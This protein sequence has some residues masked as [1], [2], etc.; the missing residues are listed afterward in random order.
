MVI[1]E[2]E[3]IVPLKPANLRNI[4]KTKPEIVSP[5]R[6]VPYSIRENELLIYF[7][8]FFKGGI[9]KLNENK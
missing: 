6:M 4:A 1:P 7:I 2:K 3:I 8:S 9:S 5:T